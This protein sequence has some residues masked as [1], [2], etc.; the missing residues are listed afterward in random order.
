MKQVNR[1]EL[2]DMVRNNEDV[3]SVDTSKIQYMDK[4][5]WRQNNFNQEIYGWNVSNVTRMSNAFEGAYSF[6]QDIS[7]WNVSNVKVIN[8]MFR[9]AAS[10]NQDISN[11]NVSNVEHMNCIFFGAV[12]FNQDISGW[13]V[14]NAR[15][16]SFFGAF[17]GATSFVN[18]KY[19]Q[20]TINSWAEQ[21][22][23]SSSE[24]EGYT[25]QSEWKK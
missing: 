6:N 10:F 16:Y 19:F 18:G 11:W 15:W 22:K 4:M 2:L 8:S 1:K 21:I 3:T 12:A 17:H 23:I 20:K 7:N 25:L 24:L 9:H 14:K 5:L 13:N